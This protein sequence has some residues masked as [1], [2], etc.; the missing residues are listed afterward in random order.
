MRLELRFPPLQDGFLAVEYEAGMIQMN[1]AVFDLCDLLSRST[2]IHEMSVRTYH[3][4]NDYFELD[5]YA[6][7]PLTAFGARSGRL[8]YVE[9]SADAALTKEIRDA[10]DAFQILR[11]YNEEAYHQASKPKFVK[12]IDFSKMGS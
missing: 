7:S 9:D 11:S 8:T 5:S 2:C 6:L 1:R 4:E 10:V 3:R 12:C